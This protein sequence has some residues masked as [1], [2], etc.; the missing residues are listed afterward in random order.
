MCVSRN[1]GSTE[2]PLGLLVGCVLG[3][4]GSVSGLVLPLSVSTIRRP[5]DH[6]CMLT[7]VYTCMHTYACIH[8]LHSPHTPAL[9][10]PELESS[11]LR[12]ALQPPAH[13]P[14]GLTPEGTARLACSPWAAPTHLPLDH[15]SLA[16]IGPTQSS[17]LVPSPTQAPSSC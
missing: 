12:A 9:V 8:T 7:H 13:G 2:V 14:E 1:Q 17:S 10:G 6:T 3:T 11:T 15:T 16:L 5:T 4:E